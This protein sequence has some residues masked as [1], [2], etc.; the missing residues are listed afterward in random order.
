VPYYHPAIFQG[1]P[2]DLGHLDPIVIDTDSEKLR[3]SIR[4]WCRFTTHVFSRRPEAGEG[5]PFILDEGH[6][7]RVFCPNRYAL[8]LHLPAAMAQLSDP[9]RYVWQTAAERNW[10]HR[11]EVR[12]VVDQAPVSYQ[13]FFAVKKARPS[14]HNVKHDVE[15]TVESAYAYDAARQPKV[16]GRMLIAGL[17]AA[18]VEERKPHTQGGRRNR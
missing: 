9:R 3:R 6:R 7:S 12:L 5:G 18:T 13:V 2:Y 14:S 8:S 4:T 15:L 1:T 10:L 16:Y 11:A 17:L